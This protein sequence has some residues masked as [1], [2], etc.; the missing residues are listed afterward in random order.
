MLT[1]LRGTR[2]RIDAGMTTAE[3]AVGTLAA[4]GFAGI[5]Y[6]IVRSQVVMNL[7]TGVITKALHTI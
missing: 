5:L 7:L 2:T 1:R 6:R 4:C 3:Y